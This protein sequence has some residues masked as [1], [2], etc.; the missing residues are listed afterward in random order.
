MAV[1][2]RLCH[3]GGQR[4]YFLCR[5]HRCVV[6]LY[7]AGPRFL[8][9]HCYRLAFTSQSETRLERAERGARKIRTR[10]GGEPDTGLPPPG[11][12]KGVHRATCD[13]LLQHLAEAEDEVDES[14]A[15]IAMRLMA[16]F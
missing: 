11:K 13:R 1:V 6:K 4:A 9:R 14:L 8:C 16:R 5:C 15:L 7:R 12:P 10:L 2:W 3:F